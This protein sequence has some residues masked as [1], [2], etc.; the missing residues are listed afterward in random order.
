MSL[1]EICFNPAQL[2]CHHIAFLPGIVEIPPGS[3]KQKQVARNPDAQRRQQVLFANR[4]RSDHESRAN[5]AI[6]FWL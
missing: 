5:L 4:S 6:S 3:A 1:P 2:V